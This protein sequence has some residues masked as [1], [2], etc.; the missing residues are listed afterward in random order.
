MTIVFLKAKLIREENI[1]DKLEYMYLRS[2]KAYFVPQ[3]NCCQGLQL[4]SICAN[5]Y[6]IIFSLFIAIYIED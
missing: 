5:T 4:A 1:S 3:N 6:S 2:L